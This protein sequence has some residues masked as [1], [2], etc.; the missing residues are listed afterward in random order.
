MLKQEIKK[1]SEKYVFY[2]FETK[3]DPTTKKHIVNYCVVQYFNGEEK[4]FTTIDQFCTWAFVN[5][6]TEHKG[7]TFI[8]HYGKGY[9]FQFV[10]EW[11]IA[12]NVKPDI[13][14]N[15]QK[16]L[17]LEIKKDYNIRFI[18]SISFT[19]MP[20]RNFPKT[21][22]LTELAKGYF[23]HKFNTD[24]NQNYI[25]SYPDKEFYDYS[26]MTKK[27]R[28]DFDIWYEKVEE[29][30]FN[31]K[32]EM[33]K[34][35]HSDV[36]ILRRGCLELRKLFMEITK[37]DPFQYITIASVCQVYY[38]SSCMPENQIA[39]Y[40]ENPT[41]NYSIKSIKWLKYIA[42]KENIFIQHACNGGEFSIMKD[43]K[44][45]KVDGYC[46][47]TRTIYQ[48]HG[49]YFHGCPA[50]YDPLTINKVSHKS[51]KFLYKRTTDI[52]NFLKQKGYTL[53]TIWEH[54]FDKDKV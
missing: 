26:Q 40:S 4:V 46:E 36:D 39:I 15:G 52:D 33:Y 21:F 29:Q 34:Y 13:I 44:S 32:E 28:E 10:A 45:I 5:E 42:E 9:D 24:Q 48:F 43:G 51:T 38:R 22:G 18:D 16:I 41:E 1:S 14:Y 6:K 53:I 54:E 47:K 2:D 37:I 8:A 20:L 50:C 17:Q 25:G 23:P 11:L 27:T 19:L 12:H 49:C 35:C 31:F 30:K 7:Y 3:L